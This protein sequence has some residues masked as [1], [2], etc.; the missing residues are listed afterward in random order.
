LQPARLL[1]RSAKRFKS[2]L[3]HMQGNYLELEKFL[4]RFE[5][6]QASNRTKTAQILSEQLFDLLP[7]LVETL[8]KELDSDL[9]VVDRL[10]EKANQNL[11]VQNILV[12]FP[13]L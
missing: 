13:D 2:S 5:S 3:Q 7:T 9:A 11:T 12:K 10:L 1:G 6:R 4:S 8:F